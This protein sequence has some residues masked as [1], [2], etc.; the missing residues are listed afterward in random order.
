V[1][2]KGRRG[3]REA[4]RWRKEAADLTA[5]LEAERSD[6][7]AQGTEE[8]GERRMGE[9]GMWEGCGRGDKDE[10]LRN[11]YKMS[12]VRRGVLGLCIHKDASQN[13]QEE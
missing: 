7:I 11:K 5:L 4:D 12:T 10:L 3:Q 8:S 2:P 9:R 1:G 6:R 13:F